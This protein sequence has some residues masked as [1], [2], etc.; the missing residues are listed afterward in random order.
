[1]KRERF[2]RIEDPARPEAEIAARVEQSC[3]AAETILRKLPV[4]RQRPR[5]PAAGV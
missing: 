4:S 5:R 3:V 2:A 1:M